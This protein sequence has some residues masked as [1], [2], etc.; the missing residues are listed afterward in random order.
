[1]WSEIV[2]LKAN[3]KSEVSGKPGNHSHHVFAKGSYALRFDTRGGVYLTA[4]EHF[5]KAHAANNFNFV[6]QLREILKKREGKNIIEILELQ[7]NRT[8]VKLEFIAMELEQ[9]LN[10]LRGEEEV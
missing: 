10:K 8:G 1:M 6:Y 9:E 7:K 2:A 3:Y 4:G 5:Y